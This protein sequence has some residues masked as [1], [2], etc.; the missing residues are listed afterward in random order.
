MHRPT[1]STFAILALTSALLLAP[2]TWAKATQVRTR[3]AQA[4]ANR[5]AISLSFGF[6]SA[7]FGS[8]HEGVDAVREGFERLNHVSLSDPKSNLQINVEIGL[9]YYLPFHILVHVGYAALYNW[10]S[11]E[12]PQRRDS[13]DNHNLIMEVP[14]LVG[15]YYVFFDRLYVYGA[16]GPSVY[17]YSRSWW[18]PGKD[19]Q[20][21]SGVGMQTQIGAD[22]MLGDNVSLGLDVR[23]RLLNAGTLTIKDT[24]IPVTPQSLGKSGSQPYEFNFSGISLVLNLRAYLF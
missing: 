15:G 12:S 17:F 18:D 11:A 20:A 7:A 23:Y 5:L 21:E 2:P 10:G 14:I 4:H 19:F 9:R 1:P 3:A 6:G 16:I 24:T 8:Y 13:F 22:F